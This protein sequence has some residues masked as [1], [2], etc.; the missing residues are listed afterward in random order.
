[1]RRKNLAVLN[2]ILKFLLDKIDADPATNTIKTL[3]F[4]DTHYARSDRL[5]TYWNH[6][7]TQI[8]KLPTGNF[9]ANVALKIFGI[10]LH[11]TKEINND[12]HPSQMTEVKLLFHLDQ[13]R[14]L[15]NNNNNG[16][17][18]CMFTD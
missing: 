3:H 5:T 4:M 11:K 9:E 14:I 15:N 17:V 6:D 8:D 7:G 10:Q 16:Q 12:A 1:M 2:N 13:A 18:E